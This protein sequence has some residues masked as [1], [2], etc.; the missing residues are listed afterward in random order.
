MNN[1]IKEIART[2]LPIVRDQVK[3]EII[4]K[5]LDKAGWKK[6]KAKAKKTEGEG[7]GK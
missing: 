7:E 6:P 4:A 3:A 2:I 5:T 1:N